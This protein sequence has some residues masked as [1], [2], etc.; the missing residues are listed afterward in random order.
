[1]HE[2]TLTGGTP[3]MPTSEELPVAREHEQIAQEQELDLRAQFLS[4]ASSPEQ[5]LAGI[6]SAD[7]SDETRSS[8]ENN[9]S[10]LDDPEIVARLQNDPEHKDEY[11]NARSLSAFHVAQQR[12]V[13]GDISGATPFLEIADSAA[14]NVAW[15]NYGGWQN[16]IKATIAYAKRDVNELSRISDGLPVG[17]SY[18]EVLERLKSGLGGGTI[19]YL[20]DY[21]SG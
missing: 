7:Q 21:G 11:Q 10:F 13:S 1:M 8:A 4:G 5:F 9:L 18:K 14:T 19:N 20:R 16:Y 3:L 6:F 2:G 12:L 17:D 15:E